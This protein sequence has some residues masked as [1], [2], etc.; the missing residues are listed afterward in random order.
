MAEDILSSET[1]RGLMMGDN[2]MTTD[3]IATRAIEA[4]AQREQQVERLKAALG[5]IY[6]ESVPHSS[7][8]ERATRTLEEIHRTA[9]RALSG[10]EAGEDT[11][12]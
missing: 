1:L 12:D 8:G 10:F 9:G 2:A 7:D 4:L 6:R 11:D 3:A 5:S